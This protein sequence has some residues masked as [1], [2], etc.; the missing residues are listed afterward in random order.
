MRTLALRSAYSAHVLRNQLTVLDDLVIETPKTK[1]FQAL[2]NDLN[3]VG[4]TLFIVD[5][6]DENVILAARNI[7][8]VAFSEV[9]HVSVYYLLRCKKHRSY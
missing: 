6:M 7:P 5:K 9:N 8:N 3:L 4:K 2:L 1:V